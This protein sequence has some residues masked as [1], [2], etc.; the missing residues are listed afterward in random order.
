MLEIKN[1]YVN[2]KKNEILK[3]FS[4]NIKKGEVHAL[5]GLN[6]AGKSTLLKSITGHFDCE[7]TKGSIKYKNENLIDMDPSKRANKGIFLSFQNPIE[8]EGINNSYFLKIAYNA[9]RVYE[10][11]KEL[12][13]LEFLKVLKEKLKKYDIDETLLK[14]D[15]NY[16]FS[17]GEKKR[18]ELL[19]LIV[20]EPDLIL[21]DE[22]D[23]GLDIDTIK[24][25]SR[26]INSLLKEGVSILMITH[27]NRL[28]E[29]IKPDFVHILDDGKI[30]KSGDYSLAKRLDKEGFANIGK[31][32][33]KNS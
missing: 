2:I 25:V 27:Y 8:I 22:I 4:L 3:D 5:M 13:S 18:N 19:Q 6:G 26:V 28:L 17:G 23:S 10:G 15:L 16:G 7:I 14:R 1:L 21:L 20:L 30:V 31:K 24:V 9:K 11:K 32:N 12:D 33:E 29:E